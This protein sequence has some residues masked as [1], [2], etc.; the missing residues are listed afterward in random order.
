MNKTATFLLASVA[1]AQ[2]AQ[3]PKSATVEFNRDV[4]P[5]LSDKCFACHGFDAKTRKADL[6]L[7]LPEGAFADNDGVRAVVPGDLKKSEAWLRIISTVED[8]VM[9]PPKSHKTMS[10]AE[11][12][13]IKRWIEQGAK[14]QKHWAFIA[15][16]R[17]VV[18]EIQSP[19]FQIRNP[20]DAFVLSRLE[21]EG[22]K[23]APEA[24]RRVL[25]RRLALDLT[26]LP[27]KPE[28]VE[29]FVKD[30]APDAYEKLVAKFMATPQWGEHRGRYWLDAARYA[31]THGLHFDKYREIW[32]YRDWV[33]AAFNRNQ[34]FD[35]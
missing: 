18:P 29:A 16:Q 10:A 11:K 26:G 21:R 12:D 5:I 32:P 23:P 33:I 34:P 25:A 15:P 17:P 24:D 9:P 6:R 35:Q 27:P 31:D 22:L 30:T 1:L 8:E 14:Y 7:D 2:A 4:R 19:K 3:E 13:V 20:I 28:E